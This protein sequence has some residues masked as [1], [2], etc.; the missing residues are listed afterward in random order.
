MLE[1]QIE[2]PVVKW[3]KKQGIKVK[4]KVFADQ[5][6]RWF[7]FSNGRLYIQEYKVPGKKLT[8]LQQL[9]IEELHKL[10]FDVEVYDDKDEAIEALKL[11]Q[12]PSVYDEQIDDYRR[13]QM[14][15]PQI[16]ERFRSLATDPCVRGAVRRSRDRQ[17]EHYSGRF[18]RT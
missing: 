1:K 9:E 16:P 12:E 18:K 14:E 3:A 13:R 7:F 17:D 2:S 6:D 4:K 5:L 15:T 8:P 11:R 10:G